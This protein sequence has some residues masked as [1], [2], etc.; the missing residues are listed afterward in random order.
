MMQEQDRRSQLQQDPSPWVQQFDQAHGSQSGPQ[1]PPLVSGRPGS[2]A[3]EYAQRSSLQPPLQGPSPMKGAA[4]A[5]QYTA[6][7]APGAAWA[8]E[9]TEAKV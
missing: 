8:E 2:W 3:D 5:E 9:F 4:W 7:S 6:S 1:R